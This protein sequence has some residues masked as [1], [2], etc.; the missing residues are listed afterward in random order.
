MYYFDPRR[1]ARPI[2]ASSIAHL[3]ALSARANIPWKSFCFTI[4]IRV[5]MADDYLHSDDFLADFAGG[6]EI[7]FRALYEE[8]FAKLTTAAD[9]IINNYMEAEDIAIDVLY[10]LMTG[11]KKFNDGPLTVNRLKNHLYLAVRHRCFDYLDSFR[12]TTS[13]SQKDAADALDNLYVES[14]EDSI[15]YAE[16][17]ARL[18][19]VL[20]GLS[21]E[22]RKALNLV[23]FENKKVKD[24]AAEMEVPLSTFH[25]IRTRA[26]QEISK[27]MP[28]KKSPTSLLLLLIYLS[29]ILRSIAVVLL[30]HY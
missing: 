30:A 14:V 19:E 4:T 11:Y 28:G 1:L 8:Y 10:R 3:L 26:F 20:E 27:K 25:H 17:I 9:G 7:A 13:A 12:R 5:L 29:S 2:A 6:K 15:V 21:E 16:G 18:T 23:Y 24:A 22:R